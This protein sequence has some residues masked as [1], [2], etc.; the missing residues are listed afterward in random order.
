MRTELAA[1]DSSA[2]HCDVEAGDLGD[3]P[4]AQK[5]T[6]PGI[7]VTGKNLE[8]QRTREA[9]HGELNRSRLRPA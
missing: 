1:F 2:H 4:R 9:L 5:L 8:R 7:L 6:P 3:L